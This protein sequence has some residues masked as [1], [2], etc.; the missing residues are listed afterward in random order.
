M[1]L[2]SIFLCLWLMVVLGCEKKHFVPNPVNEHTKDF[3]INHQNDSVQ[4][5]R[6]KALHP[7]VPFK[8]YLFKEKKSI[9]PITPATIKK[10]TFTSKRAKNYRKTTMILNSSK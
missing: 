5:I 7:K 4:S 3:P 6:F 2:R 10:K 1:V 9:S 8:R